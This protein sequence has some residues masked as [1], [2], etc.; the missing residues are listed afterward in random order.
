MVWSVRNEVY[1]RSAS[2]LDESYGFGSLSKDP[3][4]QYWTP[5]NDYSVDYMIFGR[6]S[7]V[8]G[9]ICSRKGGCT[10]RWRIRKSG[11]ILAAT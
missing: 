8:Y 1:E 5:L 11:E 9:I 2:W 6:I 4:T 10:G 7:V 3:S